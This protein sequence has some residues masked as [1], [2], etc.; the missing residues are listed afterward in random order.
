MQY[1]ETVKCPVNSYNEWDPLEEV[2]V[3]S[4]NGAMLPAWDAI[5]RHTVPPGEWDKIGQRLNP[6]GTPYPP[7]YIEAA[8]RE[9]E[10]FIHILEN[11]GVTVRR[12]EDVD[13][14]APFATPAWN[15]TSGFCGANPRDPFLVIGNEIIETPMADRSRFFE[16]WAYRELFKEYFHAGAKWTAA[17]KPQLLDSLY[18]SD[19]RVPGPDQPNRFVM[20]EFEPAFDAADFVR[21]GRDI[22]GQLSHVTNRFGVE[23]LRRHLGEEYRVHLIE[24]RCRQAIH[25]DTTLMPLAP[26]KVL[27]NPE[28]L[29]VHKLP[30]I[31][32][33]WDVLVAPE[34]VRSVNDPMGA[35]MSGWVNMNV[36]MLDEQR[37]IVEEKQTP[38]FS[39]LKNW[40]F[41]PI[42]CPFEHYYPF[43]GS[44][45]CATL[46]IRRRGEL[47]SYF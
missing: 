10:I 36:L 12:I 40:G 16:A 6:H 32:K 44:F 35:T 28:F 1:P 47:K 41:K 4:V 34:P 30:Q 9:R 25:I 24:S 37:V 19:Y 31:F 5:N 3:G 21:C 46:D 13:Y 14:A 38:M 2:I 26:G 23:W 15:V 7:E 17:P 11:E 39:A 18:D 29:D 22:F 27:V 8:N 43:W 42:S 45:H 20:T 33:S